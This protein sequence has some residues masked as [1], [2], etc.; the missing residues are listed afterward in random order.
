MHGNHGV[1]RS[2]GVR[3]V[4][5]RVVYATS[6]WI[7]NMYLLL[8]YFYGFGDILGYENINNISMTSILKFQPAP[9]A[10]VQSL[11]SGTDF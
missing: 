10:Y 7:Q 11:C 2:Q 4:P 5:E 8:I 9:G 6:M 1:F 3:Y